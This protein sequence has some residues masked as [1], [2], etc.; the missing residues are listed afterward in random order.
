MSP[1]FKPTKSATPIGS[2]VSKVIRAFD[3]SPSNQNSHPAS[4]DGRKYD[5]PSLKESSA[6]VRS[7][8]ERLCSSKAQRKQAALVYDDETLESYVKQVEEARGIYRG[9]L[10]TLNKRLIA[11]SYLGLPTETDLKSQSLP[12]IGESYVGEEEDNMTLAFSQMLEFVIQQE[13]QCDKKR[14]KRQTRMKSQYSH[15]HSAL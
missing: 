13:D 5:W 6:L 14:M 12:T 11:A 15:L 2:V 3:P 9:S 7:N 10:D 8:Y 4:E 1:S